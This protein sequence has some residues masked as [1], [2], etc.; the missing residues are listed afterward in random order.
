MIAFHRHGYGSFGA[1]RGLGPAEWPHHDLLFVHRGRLVLEFPHAAR[2]VTVE[3]GRGILIWPHTPFAGRTETRTAVASIQHFSISLPEP[4]PLSRLA[5][6]RR[7]WTEQTQ[8]ATGILERDVRR[9]QDLARKNDASPRMQAI[10][11]ALLT[12]VL[13]EGGF[14]QA[15]AQSRGRPGR[16]DLAALETW[17]RSSLG[18]SPGIADLARRAGLSP[19]RF[20]AL[21]RSEHGRTAGEFLRALR[22]EEARR[23]LAETDEPLKAIAARLGHADAVVFHR[24]F[25]ARVGCTPSEFRRRFRITG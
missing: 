23:L 9:I 17:S 20:R 2:R 25:K 19:S 15:P 10:R 11:R 1:T 7:G 8:P 6:Q 13:A 22:E 3:R 18:R 16:L 21:F 24:A 14:L 12:L 5:A 4:E